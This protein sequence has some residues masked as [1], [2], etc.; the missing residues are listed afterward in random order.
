[1]TNVV[2]IQSFFIQTQHFKAIDANPRVRKTLWRFINISPSQS[3]QYPTSHRFIKTSN[4]NFS[5]WI[6][7]LNCLNLNWL[8]SNSLFPYPKWCHLIS[9]TRLHFLYIFC[10]LN[11]TMSRRK[12]ILFIFQFPVQDDRCQFHNFTHAHGADYN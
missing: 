1:M 5:L 6:S 7:K 4:L 9:I 10:Q 3:P 12:R 8:S 11:H 2:Q